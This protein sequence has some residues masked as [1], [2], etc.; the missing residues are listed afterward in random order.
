MTAAT[1]VQAL[2]EF[3]PEVE[4]DYD[5]ECGMSSPDTYAVLLAAAREARAGLAVL[6]KK[7]ER[8]LIHAAGEKRFVVDGIGEV[9]IKKRTRRTAWRH[10]ELLPVVVARIMDEP[11]TLF[12]RESGEKLPPTVM[13]LHV[14]ARLRQCISFGAGKV[15]GLVPLGIDP[16]EFCSVESDGYAVVLPPRRSLP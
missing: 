12:D 16:T 11:G 7:I 5:R 1:I 14:A 6:E 13:G 8:D 3:A 4:I 10:D 15:T 9:E 2:T